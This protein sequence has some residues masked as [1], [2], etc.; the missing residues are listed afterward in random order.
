MCSTPWATVDG[1]A[2]LASWLRLP[3]DVLELFLETWTV[4]RY[5]QVALSVMG[6]GFATTLVPLV[7]FGKLRLRKIRMSGVL[8]ASVG[9]FAIVARGG[10]QLRPFLLPVPSN[11]TL[12]RDPLRDG[13]PAPAGRDPTLLAIQKSGVL[14]ETQPARLQFSVYNESGRWECEGFHTRARLNG[15]CLYLPPGQ[16]GER[17]WCRP[18]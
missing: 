17:R 1:V 12:E 8:A 10:T 9:L 7:Y 16:S 4:T 15:V 6:F 18:P 3:A 14:R 13:S 2:F 11:V 5:G